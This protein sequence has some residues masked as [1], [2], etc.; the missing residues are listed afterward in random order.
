MLNYKS[1]LVRHIC[2]YIIKWTRQNKTPQKNGKNEHI[3]I[4]IVTKTTE[5]TRNLFAIFWEIECLYVCFK[6][7]WNISFI[8]RT[9]TNQQYIL[10]DRFFNNRD[11]GPKD[12]YRKRECL[13]P[14]FSI[15]FDLQQTVHM[16]TL[17]TYVL[18]LYK[19]TILLGILY[20]LFLNNGDN[21]MTNGVMF[22]LL[23]KIDDI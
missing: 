19:I 6:R 17:Q 8:I 2:I 18:F 22:F 23:L 1:C 15:L 13:M 5:N 9:I 11:E 7:K 12:C 3:I 14:F 20:S 10:F 16:W 21:L 4:K